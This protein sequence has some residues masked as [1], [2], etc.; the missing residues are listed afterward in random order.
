MGKGLKKIEE[1]GNVIKIN[2]DDRLALER[3]KMLGIYNDLD[4]S[5]TTFQVRLAFAVF[6]KVNTK[7]SDENFLKLTGLRKP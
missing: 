7:L 2:G 5:S 6:N 3:L 4:V 1:K